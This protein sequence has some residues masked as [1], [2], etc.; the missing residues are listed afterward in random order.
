MGEVAI[1]GSGR[2]DNN[3]SKIEIKARTDKGSRPGARQAVFYALKPGKLKA[4]R[5]RLNVPPALTDAAAKKWAESVKR[6][7][8]RGEP[9]PQ[10]REGRKA[11][12]AAKAERE[13]QET[14]AAREAVTVAEWV[15][16]YLADCAARRVRRT[17]IR[18]RR[19]HLQQYLV[20]WAGGRR[21][22]D[23]CELDWQRL[24]RELGKLASSTANFIVDLVAEVLRA[25]ERVGLRGPVEKPARIRREAEVDVG[26][27]D[28]GEIEAYSVAEYERLVAVAGGMGDQELAVVLLGG[29]AGLRRGEIAGLRA[30]DVD[31]DGTLL[32]R[33]TIV[34][35]DGERVVHIPK[36][37]ESRRVPASARLLAVLQRLGEAPEAADGWLVRREGQPVRGEQVLGITYRVQRRARMPEKGPHKLRHTYATHMLEAGASLKEVQELLGHSDIKQTE[38]YLHAS[39]RSKRAAVEQLARHRAAAAAAADTAVAQGAVGVVSGVAGQRNR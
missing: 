29:D 4:E 2:W 10:L 24:R 27:E 28:E 5:I 38:R 39:R 11:I 21:V 31:G 30:D 1:G 36:S 18:L 19:G 14:A 12:A 9:V 33:R 7:L 20:P 23:F 32:V 22:A 16:Q 25:A 37:G 35:I 34:W 13:Q 8:E 6:A 26:A 3:V 15:E 17:T